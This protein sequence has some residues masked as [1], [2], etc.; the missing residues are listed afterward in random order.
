[1][2]PS[3]G[4]T[5]PFTKYT[6]Y[7]TEAQNQGY[8]LTLGDTRLESQIGGPITADECICADV[9][10][11]D[12]VLN[13]NTIITLTGSLFDQYN[14]PFIEGQTITQANN[15]G[16]SA[17]VTSLDSD[18]NAIIIDITSGTLTFSDPLVDAGTGTQYLP[19]PQVGEFIIP[20]PQGV[21]GSY[22]E[23]MNFVSNPSN[24]FNQ[25]NLNTLKFHLVDQSYTITNNVYYFMEND[26]QYLKWAGKILEGSPTNAPG[27]LAQEP[28]WSAQNTLPPNSATAPNGN[29]LYVGPDQI[30]PFTGNLMLNPPTKVEGDIL[31]ICFIDESGFTNCD[32][33]PTQP[34]NGPP[35]GASAT[36]N[37]LYGGPSPS[38]QYTHTEAPYGNGPNTPGE[39]GPNDV[40]TNNGIPMGTQTK[41]KPE[42]E[43]Q[44]GEPWGTVNDISQ[45]W[46]DDYNDYTTN[47]NAYHNIHGKV[48]CFLYPTAKN[49][50]QANRS[51]APSMLHYLA[52]ITSGD[53]NDGLLANP[54]FC[55]QGELNGGG[56]CPNGTDLSA[57][58]TLNPYFDTGYGALD[59]K[60]WGINLNFPDLATNG[61][62]ILNTDLTAFVNDSAICE[63]TTVTEVFQPIDIL[64]TGSLSTDINQYG[65]FTVEG[66]Y[67]NALI[68]PS[69]TTNEYSVDSTF[70][71]NWYDFITQKISETGATGIDHLNNNGASVSIYTTWNDVSSSVQTIGTPTVTTT[72]TPGP[73]VN[74][75]ATNNAY[76]ST[77]N[78]SGL[79]S[80]ITGNPT[81]QLNWLIDNGHGQNI[82]GYYFVNDT[83]DETQAPYNTCTGNNLPAGGG[84][85]SV[86]DEFTFTSLPHL[87]FSAAGGT[88]TNWHTFIDTLNSLNIVNTPGTTTQ[89]YT[90]PCSTG[91]WSN[92]TGNTNKTESIY[93]Q[94]YESNVSPTGPVA[95]HIDWLITNASSQTAANYFFEDTTSNILGHS[96]A[97]NAQRYVKEFQLVCQS[98]LDGGASQIASQGYFSS[99]MTQPYNGTPNQASSTTSD[100][101]SF[102]NNLNA[103]CNAQ[104]DNDQFSSSMT[105]AQVL[106]LIDT[107]SDNA[108]FAYEGTIPE[109]SI[110]VKVETCN[111]SETTSDPTQTQVD[112]FT[113]QDDV[114]DILTY[115]N[116]TLETV[117]SANI[118]VSTQEATCEDIP[119]DPIETEITES[120]ATNI[121]LYGSLDGGACV[122]VPEPT[123]GEELDGD[124]EFESCICCPE[125]SSIEIGCLVAGEVSSSRC[126]CSADTTETVIN[127]VSA[128]SFDIIPSSSAKTVEFR[129]KPHRL[130]KPTY[131]SL[132]ACCDPIVTVPTASHLFSLF[133]PSQP[134]TTP[135]LV[136]R[137]HTGSDVSA[138][139]DFR[140]FGALDL[141]KNGSVVGST[142]I[143]PIYNGAFWNIFIGTKGESGSSSEVYF[144]AYQSNFLGHVTHL[145][146]SATFSEYER[147]ASFGDTA[148]NIA[149]N[150]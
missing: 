75:F 121:P 49:P 56:D 78:N 21:F 112:I 11:N 88:Y 50:G 43:D 16:F 146:A 148:Y 25:T 42:W 53:N 37:A 73:P 140:N 51:A 115:F 81:Q 35:W 110:V 17:T 70:Y 97:T 7:I 106:N 149:N 13:D 142:D 124:V 26:E 127:F 132:E 14:Q 2:D 5:T 38:G 69:S 117:Y 71:T 86:V 4:I 135:H 15:N 60:G 101:N 133:N 32:Y 54:P 98:F 80:G 114:T 95:S 19:D 129:I 55:G 64:C 118:I 136:L 103:A 85:Y 45:E 10:P 139:G 72:T 137:P 91:T 65:L 90:A 77:F 123:G 34:Q 63:E 30:N 109:Y 138:S 44:F 18:S 67:Q 22:D 83:I 41:C 104:N 113:Y 20:Q 126:E 105:L 147:A 52:A 9:C 82:D 48:A 61:S 79:N 59:Q 6:D 84:V 134:Q 150:T 3:T 27:A 40:A 131:T 74:I 94:I 144:G 23:Y 92:V 33:V 46:K 36:T 28:L 119:G 31:I 111:C 57:I 87:T 76:T 93:D 100:W 116:V 24:G 141:Y 12:L 122:C 130:D 8:A 62:Q 128:S 68:E 107:L 66:F 99:M 145:T 120:T 108:R 58:S 29:P 47:Y 125:S 143:F 1:M 102:L 39:P 89:N 96:C